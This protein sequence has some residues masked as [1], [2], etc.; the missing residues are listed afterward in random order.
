MFGPRPHR[1][2]VTLV[3]DR[4]HRCRHGYGFWFVPGDRVL[5]VLVVVDERLVAAV[6]DRVAAVAVGLVDIVLYGRRRVQVLLPEAQHEQRRDDTEQREEGGQQHGLRH[7]RGE[8]FVQP[9]RKL[10]RRALALRG[11]AGIG[12]ISAPIRDVMNAA[13]PALPSTDPT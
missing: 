1:L 5:E 9:R 12:G 7:R 4:L 3:V 11:L 10:H 6:L 8:R 2:G 13:M